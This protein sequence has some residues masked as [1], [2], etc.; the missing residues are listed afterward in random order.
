MDKLIKDE[1]NQAV[2]SCGEEFVRETVPLG[3]SWLSRAETEPGLRRAERMASALR[4][5]G[6]DALTF[7]SSFMH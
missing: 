2:A 3:S 6:Y 7:R 5:T 4:C 1:Q